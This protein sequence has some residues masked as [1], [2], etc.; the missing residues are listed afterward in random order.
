MSGIFSVSSKRDFLGHLFHQLCVKCKLVSCFIA[1]KLSILNIF[2]CF[3]SNYASRKIV[4]LLFKST[5]ASHVAL[6]LLLFSAC[7]YPYTDWT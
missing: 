6:F 7:F 5:A 1:V 3:V 4:R 2:H